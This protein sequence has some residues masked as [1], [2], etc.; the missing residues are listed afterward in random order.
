MSESVLSQTSVGRRSLHTSFFITE[1]ITIYSIK[2]K[3]LKGTLLNTFFHV[4]VTDILTDELIYHCLHLSFCLQSFTAPQLPDNVSVSQLVCLVINTATPA[5]TDSSSK[6]FQLRSDF[7]RERT[8]ASCLPLP[9]SL[10][11]FV[12]SAVRRE[13]F[14]TL[15]MQPYFLLL[16]PFRQTMNKNRGNKTSNRNKLPTWSNTI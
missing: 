15:I 13:S 10:L 4:Y 9:L 1:N 2:K 7:K 8:P 5:E 16:Q 11:V 3:K 14:W 12:F 6:L